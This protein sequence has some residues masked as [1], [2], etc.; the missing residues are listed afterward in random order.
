MMHHATSG[1]LARRAT[2]AALMLCLSLLSGCAPSSPAPSV[3]GE[4]FK[5]EVLAARDS[6]APALMDAVAKREP[7]STRNILEQRCALARGGGNPFACGITILDN[8]GITL[9]SASPVEPIKRIDY[10]R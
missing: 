1:R 10:S 4:S 8:H 2:G 3:A 9:A 6:L 5:K 7:R